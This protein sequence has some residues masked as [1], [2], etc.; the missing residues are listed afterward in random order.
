MIRLTAEMVRAALYAIDLPGITN[1]GDVMFRG[2][3][4][5]D[6]GGWRVAVELPAGTRADAVVERRDALA[7]ALDLPVEQV[8][9]AASAHDARHLD[10]WVAPDVA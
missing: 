10:L 4:L 2:P 6:E 1:T 3:L 9:P 7:A 5:R 8:R